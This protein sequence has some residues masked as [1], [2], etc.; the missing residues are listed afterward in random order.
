MEEQG[1]CHRNIVE[2]TFEAFVI[3]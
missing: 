3:H 2:Q 1:T